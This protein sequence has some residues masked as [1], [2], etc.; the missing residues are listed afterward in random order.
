MNR[1]TD[2]DSVAAGY[3]VRYRNY[4]YGEITRALEAFLGAD[5]I[6]AILEV[7]CGTGHWLR[8]M[9]GRA[10]MVAGVDLSAEMIARAKDSGAALAR[11]RAESLP[12]RDAAFDR[13]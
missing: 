10:P 13:T 3:D 11:A 5:P 1:V 12:W 2:Y 8:M 7:G 4:D 9:A 6:G